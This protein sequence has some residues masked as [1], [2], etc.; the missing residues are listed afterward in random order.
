MRP[1]NASRLPDP[2]LRAPYLRYTFH[3]EKR[4]QYIKLLLSV[5]PSTRTSVRA[6]IIPE[7]DKPLYDWEKFLLV[8]ENFFCIFPALGGRGLK[9]GILQAK[10]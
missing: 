3:G 10:P 1:D 5:R 2:R 7:Y 8:Q 4:L 9:N 6:A